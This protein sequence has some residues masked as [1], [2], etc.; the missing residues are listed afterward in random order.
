MVLPPLFVPAH[1]RDKDLEDGTATTISTK[2]K[3][4]RKQVRNKVWLWKRMMV[5]P[6]LFISVI[7]KNNDRKQVRNKVWLWKRKMVLPQLFIS[8]K[9]T[10]T[11][12]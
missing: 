10:I 6:Q 8:V 5:L 11:D 3:N 1:Q 7:I 9:R 12:S 2:K 4:D